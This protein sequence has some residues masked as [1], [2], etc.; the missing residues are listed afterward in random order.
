MPQVTPSHAQQSVPSR[1]DALRPPSRERPARKR[2]RELF[3]CSEQLV[4]G[5]GEAEARSSTRARPRIAM[6][7]GLLLVLVVDAE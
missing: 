1:H 7:Y 2:R 6:V 4:V 5:V 3:S